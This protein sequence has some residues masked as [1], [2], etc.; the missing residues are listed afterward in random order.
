[1]AEAAPP[2]ERVGV[3]PLPTARP[4][5]VI[6]CL[7]P[8]L[9]LGAAQD[10]GDADLARLRAAY[11]ALAGVPGV[12]RVLVA[13]IDLAGGGA[14]AVVGEARPHA[15]VAFFRD[16]WRRK[17][18][19]WRM[20]GREALAGGPPRRFREAR[21]ADVLLALDDGAGRAWA[22]DGAANRRIT[23]DLTGQ[24]FDDALPRVLEAAGARRVDP[25]RGAV[26][27]RE[28]GG[29]DPDPAALRLSSVAFAGLDARAAVRRLMV[30]AGLSYTFEPGVDG[31][32]SL[33]LLDVPFE[34]ALREVV[35]QLHARIRTEGGVYQILLPEP[36]P[37]PPAKPGPGRRI[38][39]YTAQP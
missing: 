14:T 8:A 23:L 33:S 4:K 6:P 39:I 5:G 38:R 18:G 31:T 30:M 27:F 2:R 24:G 15:P 10:A 19:A 3:T 32:V 20:A 21:V 16:R 25:P 13:R 7:L 17:G 34:A 37:P 28:A 35:R 1:M 26:R 12:P 11:A 22:L 36:P 9:L 29:A